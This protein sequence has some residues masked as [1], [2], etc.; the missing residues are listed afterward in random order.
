MEK[1]SFWQGETEIAYFSN[2]MFFITKGEI[3]KTLVMGNFTWQ[4]ILP[5][6]ALGLMANYSGS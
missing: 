2:G 1:L 3:T 6:K 5:D 4:V